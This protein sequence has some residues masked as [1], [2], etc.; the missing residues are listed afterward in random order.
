MPDDY[1][2][3]LESRMDGFSN[4]PRE[5]QEMFRAAYSFGKADERGKTSPL[6]TTM[7]KQIA[8]MTYLAERYSE[9]NPWKAKDTVTVREGI[10]LKGAG[11]PMVVLE[12]NEV[13]ITGHGDPDSH[14]QHFQIRPDTRCLQVLR[15]QAVTFWYEHWQLEAYVP[16]PAS[17]TRN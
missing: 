9:K 11:F 13:P 16:T 17:K 8:Q 14:D 12:A 1:E 10:N 5:V 15:G 7:D 6:N 3:D 4:M 2:D